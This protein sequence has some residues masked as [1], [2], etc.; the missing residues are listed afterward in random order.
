[1]LETIF[2]QHVL[3]AVFSVSVDCKTQ[4]FCLYLLIV[5]FRSTSKYLI[6]PKF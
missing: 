3:S 4:I 5:Y 6:K 1:M 2:K